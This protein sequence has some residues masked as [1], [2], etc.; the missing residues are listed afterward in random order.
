MIA[1]REDECGRWTNDR[2]ERTRDSGGEDAARLIMM[3]K[4]RQ[5]AVMGNHDGDGK[6]GQT[7]RR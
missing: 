2:E 3:R 7:K 4:R 1:V 6:D 5:V